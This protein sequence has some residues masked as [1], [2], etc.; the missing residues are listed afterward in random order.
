[1]QSRVLVHVHVVCTFNVGRTCTPRAHHVHVPCTMCMP[2][3]CACHVHVHVQVDFMLA[4]VPAHA[5]ILVI[6]ALP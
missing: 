6:Q 1:M 3:P 5:R 4:T 2:C